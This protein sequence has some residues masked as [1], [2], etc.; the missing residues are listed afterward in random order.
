M[1]TVCIHSFPL[2]IYLFHLSTSILWAFASFSTMTHRSSGIFIHLVR[3]VTSQAPLSHP[4]RHYNILVLLA[5]P[6]LPQWDYISTE[7]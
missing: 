2:T 3:A 4:K 1:I 7:F 6:L 5:D